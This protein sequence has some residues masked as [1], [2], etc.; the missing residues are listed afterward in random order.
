VFATIAVGV[1]L[2]LLF[3]APRKFFVPGTFVATTVMIVAALLT[4]GFPRKRGASLRGV[5]LGILS[6]AGLYGVFFLGNY[7]VHSLNIPGLGGAQ[8]STIYSLIASASNRLYLQV[9][10][11]LFDA[12]GYESFFRGTLQQGLQERIGGWGVVPVSALDAAL[13][14]ATLNPLW[15]ATTFL[16]DIVWGIT[17][18]YGRG[19]ASSAT[20]HF[21]WDLAIFIIRPIQ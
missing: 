4:R 20:S 10:V 17:Y 18:Y 7:A 2:T 16:A 14:I 13:H 8:E 9:G 1:A 19:F 11:L 6:A 5:L 12:V 15:V 3:L 21:V